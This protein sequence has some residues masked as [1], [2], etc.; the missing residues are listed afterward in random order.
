VFSTLTAATPLLRAYCTCRALYRDRQNAHRSTPAR[1]ART[2]WRSLTSV[3]CGSHP[4]ICARSESVF[5]S[6]AID[7]R[8]GPSIGAPP[9]PAVH[10]RVLVAHL[11][12]SPSRARHACNVRDRLLA[13]SD[14]GIIESWESALNVERD[15]MMPN[16]DLKQLDVPD[17]EL[18]LGAHVILVLFSAPYSAR[19]SAANADSNT[20]CT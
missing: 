15:A 11:G 7:E 1:A 19:A 13:A 6:H 18:H 17:F 12:S 3:R 14:T 5:A 16:A 2:D 9:S 10:A 4:R 20:R 8:M